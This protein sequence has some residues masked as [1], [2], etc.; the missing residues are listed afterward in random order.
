MNVDLLYCLLKSDLGDKYSFEKDECLGT[1]HIDSDKGTIC[2]LI[3]RN[4]QL[5]I[6]KSWNN[7]TVEKYVSILKQDI[8]P[9]LNSCY[10]CLGMDVIRLTDIIKR[11]EDSNRFSFSEFGFDKFDYGILCYI[12]DIRK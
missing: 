5:E 4:N 8:L 12:K 10:N 9:T 2:Y 11:G 7:I 3:I 1:I 6:I